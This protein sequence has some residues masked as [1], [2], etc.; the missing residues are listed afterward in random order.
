MI[1][2]HLPPLKTY[3]NPALWDRLA[4]RVVEQRQF[5][6]N[7]VV[8]GKWE[9][10]KKARELIGYIQALDWI[11]QTAADLTR[12]EAGDDEAS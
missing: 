8:D 3:Y 2:D 4:P 7:A 9:S 11:L 5:K 6:V 1:P 10:V 12:V